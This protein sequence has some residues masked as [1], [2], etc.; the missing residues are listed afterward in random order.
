MSVTRFFTLIALFAC[1]ATVGCGDDPPTYF[2]FPDSREYCVFP[3]GSKW[4]YKDSISGKL[5]SM[6]VT[7]ID[8]QI[9]DDRKKFGGYFEEIEVTFSNSGSGID[10]Y[11]LFWHGTNINI[12]SLRKNVASGGAIFASSKIGQLGSDFP[13]H[14]TIGAEIDTLLLEGS[15]YENVK[16]FENSDSSAYLKRTW[17]A[18]NKGLIKYQ[19]NQGKVY[20][21][22][23]VSIAK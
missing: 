7:G 22:T 5:D 10:N 1:I 23:K 19:T 8:R 15:L 13:W 21:A 18:R 4:V 3:V 17:F 12:V 20:V 2:L 14:I 11:H 6:Q 9:I 16:V